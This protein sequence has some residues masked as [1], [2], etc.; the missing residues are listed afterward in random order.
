HM[1]FTPA[2]L[3]AALPANGPREHY[4]RAVSSIGADGAM[5]AHPAESQDSSLLS[6]FRDADALIRMPPNA[7]AMEPGQSVEILHLGREAPPETAK[8]RA[9]GVT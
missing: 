6:V 8:I 4:L 7:P 3:A 5:L 2:R 1:G 9:A